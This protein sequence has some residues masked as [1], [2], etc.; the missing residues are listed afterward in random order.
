M[1]NNCSAVR[2]LIFAGLG[3]LLFSPAAH[4][5]GGWSYHRH[6]RPYYWREARRPSLAVG[7]FVGGIPYDHCDGRFYRSGPRGYVIVPAVPASAV[8]PTVA[9]QTIVVN[10]PNKNGSYTPVKLQPASNGTYIGPEGEVYPNQP[11]MEQL[12]QMYGK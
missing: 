3:V 9:L 2:V 5:D 11:T 7:I 6:D 1:K 10:V 8:A 12:K 4:A